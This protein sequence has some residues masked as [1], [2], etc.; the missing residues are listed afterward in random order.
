MFSPHDRRRHLARGQGVASPA[1]RRRSTWRL[2][3][4]FL[5][6]VPLLLLVASAGIVIQG[7]GH[8]VVENT[9]R[10]ERAQR[11]AFTH[12]IRY[13]DSCD[14]AEFQRYLEHVQVLWAFEDARASIL[15]PN[16]NGIRAKA[17]Y[18]RAGVSSGEA[19]LLVRVLPL[20]QRTELQTVVKAVFAQANDLAH[21]LDQEAA[22]LHRTLQGGCLDPALHAAA[23]A[24]ILDLDEQIDALRQGSTTL[25]SQARWRLNEAVLK[26]ML[27]LVV[28]LTVG[29]YLLSAR[30]QRGAVRATDA[31]DVSEHRLQR[32]LTG[33]G[34]GLWDMEVS[35]GATYCSASLMQMLGREERDQTLPHTEFMALMHP[36]EADAVAATVLQRIKDGQRLDIELRLRSAD[37]RHR[38][39]RMAG[40]VARSDRGGPAEQVERRQ[41]TRL[42]GSLFDIDDRHALQRALEDELEA[43]RS[44]VRAL[45][46]TIATLVERTEPLPTPSAPSGDD[47]A[48][49]AQA[50]ADLGR[51]LRQTN[52]QLEAIIDLSPDGFVSFDK[53]E[54]VGFVSPRIA[55]LT[56]LPAARLQ[57]QHAT[58]FFDRLTAMSRAGV[59]TPSLRLLSASSICA[60]TSL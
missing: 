5:L 37:G 33:S 16:R 14:P 4:P 35:T 13:T 59:S 31:L 26:V 27:V 32:A 58:A 34:A 24:P 43:R 25:A 46:A 48:A 39:F 29:G 23:L 40:Q 11:S 38:W 45:R 54:R 42:I 6:L 44:A 18:L 17:A 9:T 49:V 1:H 53:D 3:W 15:G 30:L 28:P 21:Q 51:Q 10:W 36:D 2:T 19:E 20:L 52:S 56:G 41:P 47:M 55:E 22:K 60:I 7:V 57:G 12:L 8:V 50:V